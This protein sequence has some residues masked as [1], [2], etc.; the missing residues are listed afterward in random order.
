MHLAG[1]YYKGNGWAVHIGELEPDRRRHYQ[2]L[3]YSIAS[4]S[5]WGKARAEVQFQL[6]GAARLAT[7]TFQIYYSMQSLRGPVAN[8]VC[9]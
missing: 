4:P 5:T 7:S 6:A 9:L 2:V 3:G 1:N 8:F